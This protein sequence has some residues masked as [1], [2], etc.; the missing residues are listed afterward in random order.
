MRVYPTKYHKLKIL[1]NRL[2]SKGNIYNKLFK[3]ML[4][5]QH[6]GLVLQNEN[7]PIVRAIVEL[8]SDAKLWGE[9]ELKVEIL[10]IIQN[11][12]WK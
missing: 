12:T 9:G 2:P 7:F 6:L 5:S 3:R 1:L 4:T 8:R 10:D 11:E